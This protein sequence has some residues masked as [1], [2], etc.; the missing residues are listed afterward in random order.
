MNAS[1][2]I[3]KIWAK[4]AEFLALQDA[5]PEAVNVA[6][7][8]WEQVKIPI[9]NTD[10]ERD[11]AID[12]AYQLHEYLLDAIP[13]GAKAVAEAAKPL[14][15]SEEVFYNDFIYY[16]FNKCLDAV[17]L[18]EKNIGELKAP[19]ILNPEAIEDAQ[20]TIAYLASIG[21]S[22]ISISPYFFNHASHPL[23][24][25]INNLIK[26][27]GCGLDAISMNGIICI[28][29]ESETPTLI[30]DEFNQKS[31]ACF[32]SLNKQISITPRGHQAFPHEWMHALEDFAK[33]FKHK[34]AG[35]LWKKIK[36]ARTSL[37]TMSQDNLELRGFL[38]HQIKTRNIES[39]MRENIEYFLEHR[40]SR[41]AKEEYTKNGKVSR[42]F[43]YD[44]I[45]K[46]ASI[47]DINRRKRALS[48]FFS[49]MIEAGQPA[50]NPGGIDYFCEV[51]QPVV[52]TLSD[53]SA[54]CSLFEINAR[55]FD[56][57]QN[58]QQYPYWAKSAE[59][60]AR[61][62]E[63]YASVHGNEMD[64]LVGT[65]YEKT[66]AAMGGIVREVQALFPHEDLKIAKRAPSI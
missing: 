39:R 28:S 33:E 61:A 51:I 60:L 34:G 2:L 20:W 17:L 42:Q 66:M 64:Y 36:E 44:F 8:I 31:Q 27:L 12:I 41:D 13:N 37:R 22:K 23:V 1:N 57:L 65:E 48:D 46:M 6:R 18:I 19:D 54:G 45:F 9:I 49:P 58:C 63:Q 25:N 56:R 50:I 53:A 47:R 26:T 38:N 10:K 5:H 55:Y 16:K 59:I 14:L 62:F 43:V 29:L 3:S 21:F 24:S 11:A 4:D 52:D 15:Y 32:S 7:A 35:D 30:T 40:A